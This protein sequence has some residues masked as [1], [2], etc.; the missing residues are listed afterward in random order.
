MFDA[1][2][3]Y[4]S[5]DQDPD[6][7]DSDTSDEEDCHVNGTKIECKP[8]YFACADGSQCI[9]STWQWWVKMKKKIIK[10]HGNLNK[11]NPFDFSDRSSDCADGSD[12]GE[13][14]KSRECNSTM[15][16]CPES[17]RCIPQVWVCDGESI[18]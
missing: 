9:P 16:R 5:I 3:I 8:N 18:D 1:Y 14:C 7:P 6:C 11:M 10:R 2:G 17:G 13:H 4:A 15:F 12:E